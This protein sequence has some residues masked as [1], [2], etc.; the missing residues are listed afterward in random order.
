MPKNK[1]AIQFNS[2]LIHH[3]TLEFTQVG[4]SERH[5]KWSSKSTVP[6]AS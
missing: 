1:T 6:L 5:K 2:S 3:N 4:N